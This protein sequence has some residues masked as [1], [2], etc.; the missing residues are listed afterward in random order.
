MNRIELHAGQTE[1]NILGAIAMMDVKFPPQPNFKDDK[2]VTLQ[3]AAQAQ[4]IEAGGDGGPGVLRYI[5]V[6]RGVFVNIDGNF[7]ARQNFGI[8]G[9]KNDPIFNGRWFDPIDREFG[10]L[11]Q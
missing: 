6:K 2:K 3:Q 8:V 1:Q 11:T 9:A 7:H 4:R 10:L 5:F